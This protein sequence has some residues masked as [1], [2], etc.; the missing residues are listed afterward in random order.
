MGETVGKK[1]SKN[2]YVDALKGIAC[3]IVVLLHCPFPGIIGAGIIYGVRFSVPV[4]FMISGYYSFYKSDEWILDKAKY[5]LQLLIFSELFYGVWTL[6]YQC[7]IQKKSL[8]EIFVD[9]LC[10]INIIQTVFFGTFFN[11]TLWYLY[12]IFWTWIV[13]YMLRK[14]KIADKCYFLVPALLFVQVFGRMY[15]QNH[16]DIDVYVVW[17][18]NVLTFGL[19]F[20]MLGSWIA[21]YQQRL[22]DIFTK[23][24]NIALI[25]VG[26]GLI[27]LEF[28]LY[29]QYMDTHV[30]TIVIAFALFLY[31]IRQKGEVKDFLRGFAYIGARWSMWIYLLHM[32][33]SQ[34]FQV[35]FQLLS[36]EEFSIFQYGKPIFVCIVTCLLSEIFVR[37]KALK[38]AR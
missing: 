2:Q 33:V 21:R 24:K 16:Y 5:I 29:G 9:K 32:F 7:V 18:R 12:A 31:A 27:V 4:F 22:E 14:I 13:L 36:L 28:F 35:F 1:A 6:I 3:L 30:S 38:I 20:T 15:V 11:G 23:K 26:F 25:G 10:D 19:P 17:F 37:I 8:A 34:L